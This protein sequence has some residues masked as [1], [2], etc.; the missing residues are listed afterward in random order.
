VTIRVKESENRRLVRCRRRTGHCCAF[1]WSICEKIAT[2]LSA[3][4]GT[5][6]KVMWAYTIYE[7]TAS[8]KENQHWQKEIFLYWERFLQKITVLQHRW[9][10]N[11]IF[12]LKTLFLRKLPDVSFTDP[13][14]TVAVGL[15]LSNLW[16]LKVMLRFRKDGV[17]TTKPGHRRTGNACVLWSD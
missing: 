8:V 7:K 15:Q 6:S 4:I 5:G 3:A 13:T 17:T 9:Q 12:I 10:Q 16:L 11:W 14:S 1:N 2:L